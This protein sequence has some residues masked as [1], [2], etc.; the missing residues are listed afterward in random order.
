M[1]ADFRLFLNALKDVLNS[2]RIFVALFLM[3]LPAIIG[4][5]WKSA[6]GE[7]FEALESYNTLAAGLVFGFIL[8]ILSVIYG[9]GVLSQELEGRT[10]VYL[11]TRPIPRW[12]IL[13][14]KYLGAWLA[15]TVTVSISE[16][17]LALAMFGTKLSG[18]PLMSDI[19]I[20]PLGAAAY[21]ALF[22][23]LATLLSKPL[24]YGLLFA[25]GWESWVP[26]LPGGFSRWSIM[27]YLRTL[28]PHL[29]ETAES[30]TETG[31]GGGGDI[32]EIL[33][34]FNPVSIP[35]ITAWFAI[36]IITLVCL[37]LSLY[38]FSVREYSP[39]EEAS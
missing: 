14:A 23:L 5:I 13:L 28:A 34:A 4:L 8:T 15:I 12:R 11:L 16:V 27:A 6:A 29:Q 37:G 39:K 3:V 19:K 24:S 33:M 17:L 25:F 21:G 36:P 38:F 2:R 22:L 31:G 1:T 32:S 7:R 26:S 30:T 18:V 20:I 9:T 10:I 35:P